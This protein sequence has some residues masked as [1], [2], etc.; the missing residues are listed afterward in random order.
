M[1]TSKYTFENIS[2]ILLLN[3]TLCGCVRQAQSG[4]KLDVPPEQHGVLFLLEGNRYNIR[5]QSPL[6]RIKKMRLSILRTRWKL[7]CVR[8]GR[9]QAFVSFLSPTQPA[10]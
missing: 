3:N 1:D 5:K 8:V 4:F 10:R 7:C 6:R 9:A 2:S